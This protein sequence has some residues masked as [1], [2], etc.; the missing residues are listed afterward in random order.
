LIGQRGFFRA[1]QTL[2]NN[3][4]CWLT[5]LCGIA[6]FVDSIESF[7]GA[8]VFLLGLLNRDELLCI[9]RPLEQKYAW[10]K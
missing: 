7:S 1:R 3:P 8:H 5:S 2:V 9:M 6:R 10:S 4:R